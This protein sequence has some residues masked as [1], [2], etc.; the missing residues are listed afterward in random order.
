[1]RLAAVLGCLLALVGMVAGYAYARQRIEA[2]DAEATA[3]G[4]PLKAAEGRQDMVVKL[5]EQRESLRGQVAEIDAAL[6]RRYGTLEVLK[7]ISEAASPEVE[8]KGFTMQMDQPLVIRGTAPDSAVVADLQAKMEASPLLTKVMI[9]RMDRE[10]NRPGRLRGVRRGGAAGDSAGDGDTQSVA[11]VIKARLR[12]EVDDEA[13][14]SSR[15]RRGG[16]K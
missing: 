1:V 3:L 14:A 16:S 10:F 8:L 11:F 13:E 15:S 4:R 12:I 9:E 7:A 2:R 5:L 6:L